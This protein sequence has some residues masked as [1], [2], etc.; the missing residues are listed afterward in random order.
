MHCDE[1]DAHRA[2]DVAGVERARRTSGARRNADALVRQ[3]VGNCFAFNVLKTDV[4]SI[5]EAMFLI[6]IDEY[7]RARGHDAAFEF[8][9]HCRQLHC[10]RRHTFASEFAGFRKADDIGDILRTCAARTFLMTAEHE[11]F[12]FC[13]AAHVQNADALGGV[14]L[15]SAHGEEVNGHLLDVDGYL[16]CDLHGIRMKGRAILLTNLGD[17]LDGEDSAC[18]VISPH[19]GDERVLCSF[20]FVAQLIEVDL[21]DC[22]DGE[23][24]FGVA[25][26]FEAAAGLQD[27][28][29]LDRGRDDFCVAAVEFGGAANGGV[30]TFCRARGEDD[31]IGFAIEERGNFFAGLGEVMGD[32]AA[33]GMHR[34]RVAI[35]FAEEREHGVPNFWCDA[36]GRIVIKIDCPYHWRILYHIFGVFGRG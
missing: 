29:M 7:I 12:E 16:A 34:A 6:A 21:A 14:K 22:V 15:M 23:F 35:Q 5:R 32:L 11:G 33:E 4:E 25:Q 10:F 20:E 26:G 36:R 27:G 30:I 18:L 17:L 3:M 28:R 2:N 1:G 19:N 8:I 31:F 24:D 9:A 13:A